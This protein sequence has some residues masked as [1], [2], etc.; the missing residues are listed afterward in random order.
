[1][2]RVRKNVLVIY[3][4][5]PRFILL[6]V[7]SVN[8]HPSSSKTIWRGCPQASEV[9][10]T[11]S[12]GFLAPSALV[13]MHLRLDRNGAL[14]THGRSCVLF[15]FSL[16]G[17]FSNFF[18]PVTFFAIISLLVCTGLVRFFPQKLVGLQRR[19]IY[20]LWGHPEEVSAAH[21]HLS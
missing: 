19:T 18:L 15:S 10:R 2:I 6:S 11:F 9:C 14:G 1:V 17:P 16:S 13:R 7:I 3:F 8:G 5:Q 12:V 4:Y 20:Y 21:M